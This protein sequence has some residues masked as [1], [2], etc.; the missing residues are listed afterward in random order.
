MCVLGGGVQ[1]VWC[2]VCARRVCV[3]GGVCG[4]VHAVCATSSFD[5]RY[6]DS[7]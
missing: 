4:G 6:V 2:V 7:A 3:C 1:A 5:E